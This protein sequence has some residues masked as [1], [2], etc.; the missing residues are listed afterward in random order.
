MPLDDGLGDAGG[1]GGV[2]DPQGVFEGHRLEGQLLTGRQEVTPERGV[3]KALQGRR[4]AAVGHDHRGFQSGEVAL[5]LGRPGYAVEL[6]AAVLVAPDHQEHLGLQLAEPVHH[7]GDAELG[8]AA[9][10]DGADARH[11]QEGRQRLGDVGHVGHH[12]VALLYSQT[13]Q[14]G[15][16]FGGELPELGVGERRGGVALRGEEKRRMV[17][18]AVE[19][20]LGVVQLGSGEP[21]GA[22]H[23]ALG[24]DVGV[25]LVRLHLEVVPD[26]GPERLHLRHGPL[27]EL[28]VRAE[29][30]APLLLEPAHVAGHVALLQVR[31][32]G[33]PQKRS[34]GHGLGVR[35]LLHGP[36]PPA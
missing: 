34:F 8:W 21:S 2:E 15:R 36:L 18:A 14:T 20:V 7:T 29:A 5:E 25:G 23:G 28:I 4:F 27:P 6:L 13:A 30:E 22:L 9:R 35:S 17:V 24:Q 31:R 32:R 33:L 1:A 16:G 11:G 3:H 26:A 12:P 10:P 19:H